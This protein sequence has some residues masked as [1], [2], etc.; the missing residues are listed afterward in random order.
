MTVS[1]SASTKGPFLGNGATTVF[2]WTGMRVV[3]ESH[4]S[5]LETSTG[6]DVEV[7][8]GFSIDLLTDSSGEITFDTAPA[9]GLIY[10]ISRDVPNTQETDYS[11][12]GAVPP[13][14]V[15]E[16]LDL[17]A[18]QVQDIAGSADRNV[19]TSIS[20]GL[21]GILLTEIEAGK[22]LIADDD[23]TSIVAGPTAYYLEMAPTYVAEAQAAQAAAEE[24]VKDAEQSAEDAED[25]AKT[26]KTYA[27]IATS[28]LASAQAVQEQLTEWTQ[29][30]FAL[31]GG[32]YDLG[33][34]SGD[35]YFPTDLGDLS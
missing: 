3:D 29:V 2:S 7:T 31:N 1:N 11:N 24:A 19:K 35:T 5:V 6:S 13:A 22:V 20:S 26:A 33:D 17:L 18:M 27:A 25:E 16:D 15:E 30:S 21:T 8:D 4:L 34:L 28:T 32:A 9:D 12:Q 14:Q 10:Y 23:G